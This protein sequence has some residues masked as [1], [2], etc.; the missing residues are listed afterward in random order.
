MHLPGQR[1]ARLDL[2]IGFPLP[3]SPRRRLED[4][5][6]QKII[7]R[8]QQAAALSHVSML[9]SRSEHQPAL[10][11]QTGSSYQLLP[12]VRQQPAGR[13]R[14]SL[15]EAASRSRRRRY[16]EYAPCSSA[17]RDAS[18]T[19][20]AEIGN[21]PTS[22]GSLCLLASLAA[23]SPDI[24]AR[25][26]KATRGRRREAVTAPPRCSGRSPSAAG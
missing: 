12:Y 2:R 14:Q 21:S 20:S 4:R 22:I 16:A 5:A 6:Q 25:D 17:Q 18:S 11:I 10:A 13:C 7:V 19:A 23:V 1:T 24:D 8:A 26:R 3:P 9:P 15:Y